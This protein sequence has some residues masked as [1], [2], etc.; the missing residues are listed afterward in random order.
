MAKSYPVLC[1]SIAGSIGGMGVKM[2]NAAFKYM[3]LPYTYVSFEPDNIEDTIK[4]MKNLGIRG[5]GVTMPFKQ[6]IIPYLDDLDSAAREIGAVNTVVNEEGRLKGYNTDSY[7]A[8]TTLH[9]ATD[10]KDKKVVIL[11]AGGVARTIIWSLLK[12]TKDVIVYNNNQKSGKE[13]AE[14]FGVVFAGEI[15]LLNSDI[16]YDILINCTSVGFKSSETIVTADRIRPSTFVMDVVFLPTCTTFLKEAKS[17]GCVTLSGTRMI[18]HQA[19]K[20]FELYTGVAAPFE[21]YEK[22]MLE[23]CRI[24]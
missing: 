14:A 16:E 5:L 7:G 13:V 21:I 10:L 1:G 2:H 6:A 12:Y 3:N 8:L 23:I 19:C 4:A 18:M 24:D 9:E 17:V 20:Q 22:T 11:G 15:A